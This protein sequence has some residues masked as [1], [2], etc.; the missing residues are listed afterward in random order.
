MKI[1]HF[2]HNS[3][4]FGA[5]LLLFATVPSLAAEGQ[6]N[7]S[8]ELMAM[9]ASAT[10]IT[11]TWTSPGDDSVTGTAAQYDI[12]YSTSLI[13]TANFA[14]A[15]QVS[16]ETAPKIAGSA[17]TFT[18]TGLTPSTNYYFAI[19]TADEV[20]NWSGI[21]NV[22]SISTLDNVPPAAIKNLAVQQ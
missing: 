21:S 1:N 11:L 17:E 2:L 5:A 7:P 6:A 16:G 12:R 15:T 18:V 4:L 3:L 8:N 22:V 9:P 10:S 13:T 19:K 20:P 14:S